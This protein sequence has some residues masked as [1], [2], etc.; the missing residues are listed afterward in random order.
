M[1]RKSRLA[2]RLADRPVRSDAHS[3]LAKHLLSDPKIADLKLH[4]LT[5]EQLLKCRQRLPTSLLA[6]TRQR[7]FSDAKA[8]FNLV[9]KDYRKL[10]PPDFS[11]TI[12]FGL[13]TEDEEG[14][15]SRALAKT[16]CWRMK[17]Y[18]HSFDISPKPMA[19]VTLHC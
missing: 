19:M 8:A 5:E 16:R 10:L 7:L 6:T 2:S 12:K 1:N 3:R 14:S 9:Y 13:A 4:A 15:P 17:K 11:Q 18:D